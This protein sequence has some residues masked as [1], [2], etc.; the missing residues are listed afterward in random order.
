MCEWNLSSCGMQ[1]VTSG[2][3]MLMT[4]DQEDELE[5]LLRQWQTTVQ[6]EEAINNWAVTGGITCNVNDG[7]QGEIDTAELL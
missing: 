5:Y 1:K 7:S 4:I 2:Q 3:S 6:T